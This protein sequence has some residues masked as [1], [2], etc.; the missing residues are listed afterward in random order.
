MRQFYMLCDLLNYYVQNL[1]SEAMS[2][3]FE[4]QIG[5]TPST[6]WCN[7]MFWTLDNNDFLFLFEKKTGNAQGILS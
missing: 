7:F 1:F 5:H 3:Q 6:M 4:A 2:Y